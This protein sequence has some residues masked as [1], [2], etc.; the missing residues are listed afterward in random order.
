M[1][2]GRKAPTPRRMGAHGL[3]NKSETDH[4]LR[5]GGFSKWISKQVVRAGGVRRDVFGFL[6]AD[7]IPH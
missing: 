1:R 5:L 6:A 3:Q 2:I 7:V 4:M